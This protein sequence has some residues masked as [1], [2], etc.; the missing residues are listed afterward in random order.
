MEKKL[1]DLKKEIQTHYFIYGYE[2]QNYLQGILE[3]FFEIT[4]KMNG[5]E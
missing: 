1:E 5:E 3:D 4:F 2:K